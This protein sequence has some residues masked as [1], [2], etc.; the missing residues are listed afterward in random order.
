[1]IDPNINPQLNLWN[2]FCNQYMN[3]YF[4]TPL[5]E[6]LGY[7]VATKL[8]GKT[9]KLLLKRSAEMEAFVIQEV[10]LVLNDFYG[11]KNEYEGLIYMIYWHEENLVIPLYIGKSEKYGRSGNNLSANICNIDRNMNKDKFC[12]WGDSYAYHIGDLSAVVC[13]GHPVEKISRKYQ[14]WADRLFESYPTYYPK[15]RQPIYFWIHAWKT[16]SLGIWKDFGS[17]ALTALEYHLISVGSTIFSR[18]LLNEE[19]VNRKSLNL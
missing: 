17:T 9:N 12:R 10:S 18:F 13:P 16:G 11:A 15:L 5:F 4:K 7:E 3:N 19:G 1:M 2:E 6:T 14:K 8:Y